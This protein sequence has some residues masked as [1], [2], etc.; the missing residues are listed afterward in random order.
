MNAFF[1]GALGSYEVRK[2]TH[3]CFINAFAWREMVSYFL[4]FFFQ[5]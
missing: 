4:Q 5:I 1:W 3:D 2:I